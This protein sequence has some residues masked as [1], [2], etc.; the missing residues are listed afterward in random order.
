MGEFSLTRSQEHFFL[1]E[2]SLNRL[3]G[4]E[5]PNLM[6]YCAV[7]ASLVRR[8]KPSTTVSAKT[9]KRMRGM[10]SSS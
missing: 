8:M 6:A 2:V 10:R 9:C 7:R 5:T 1:G 3:R 4:A